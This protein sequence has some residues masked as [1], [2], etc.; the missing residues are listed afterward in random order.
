MSAKHEQGESMG[1]K[2]VTDMA[3]TRLDGAMKIESDAAEPEVGGL[4]SERHTRGLS[5][6]MQALILAYGEPG[7][8]TSGDDTR[9][10][11]TSFERRGARRR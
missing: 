4:A 10:V 3:G 9:D 5:P 11:R 2:V 1:S 6:A 7:A 8:E